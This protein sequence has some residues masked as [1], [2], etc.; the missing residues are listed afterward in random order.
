MINIK[1]IFKISKVLKEHYKTL[2][3]SVCF[4]AVF[5]E[6]LLLMFKV[7]FLLL[8]GLKLHFFSNKNLP[9]FFYLF[10]LVGANHGR[11]KYFFLRLSAS[12]W[13]VLNA[14]TNFLIK[15]YQWWRTRREKNQTRQFQS[16]IVLCFERKSPFTIAVIT[17]FLQ[18]RKPHIHF[19]R[20]RVSFLLK[21]FATKR[22]QKAD[23][24]LPGWKSVRSIRYKNG[25]RK[26]RIY[27]TFTERNTAQKM[28]FP[29]KEFF[30]KC[31]ET[32]FFTFTEETLN[33]KSHFLVAV[34][35]QKLNSFC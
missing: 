11:K 1:Y 5:R 8:W 21:F 22:E 27:G 32:H 10:L 9:P 24:S 35:F 20:K 13:K 30:S 31:E 34:K 33:G 23:L 17:D 19:C 28:K 26:W 15:N 12:Y 14:F 16:A 29:I 7:T 4:M 3:D 6:V 18:N 25:E 2:T